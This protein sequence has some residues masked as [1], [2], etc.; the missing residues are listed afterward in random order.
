[1]CG[2]YLKRLGAASRVCLSRYTGHGTR[3]KRITYSVRRPAVRARGWRLSRLAAPANLLISRFADRCHRIRRNP[4][5]RQADSRLNRCSHLRRHLSNVRH[6]PGPIFRVRRQ[7]AYSFDLSEA[8]RLNGASGRRIVFLWGNS[9][10]VWISEA[11]WVFGSDYS[12]HHLVVKRVAR[13]VA[14]F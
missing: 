7:L 11:H 6:E 1:M 4:P 5:L 8:L 14:L 12:L 13:I 2:F 9:G 10:S 3:A